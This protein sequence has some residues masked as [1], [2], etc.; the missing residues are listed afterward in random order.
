MRKITV[1]AC[2][3]SAAA[4]SAPASAT[5]LYI[6][7]MGL[8]DGFE[9][10]SFQRD[11]SKP[12]GLWNGGTEY[13]GRQTLTANFG[14]TDDPAHHFNV[15]AW[16]ID[17]FHDIY[18]GADSIVYTLGPAGVPY[19][20]DIRKLA[21]WGDRQLALSGP[22]PLISAA[23]QATIWDLEYNMEIVP[24]SNPALEA[25][26]TDIDA[27]LPS[28]P[29]AYGAALSGSYTQGGIAQTLYTTKAPEPAS[30]ALF[31]TGLVA[32]ALLFQRKRRTKVPATV[33][34]RVAGIPGASPGAQ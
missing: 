6:S 23:V 21:T 20:S 7:G 27:M 19:A 14:T 10:V 34:Y 8:N 22:N 2:L 1:V 16:C 33:R 31:S 9:M 25:E 3:L 4:L 11:P 30:L 26:L 28:L 5:E 24:G 17:V 13:T 32:L 12:A 18:I 29:G 15:F